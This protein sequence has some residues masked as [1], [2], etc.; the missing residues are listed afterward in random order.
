MRQL[1]MLGGGEHALY[2]ISHF[3][4]KYVNNQEAEQAMNKPK[5]WAF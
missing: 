2:H 1:Y 5:N 3:C 4:G